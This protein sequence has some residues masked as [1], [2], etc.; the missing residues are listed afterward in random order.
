MSL[1]E[2]AVGK[3]LGDFKFDRDQFHEMNISY[4]KEKLGESS[5]SRY[6]SKDTQVRK[7]ISSLE[8]DNIVGLFLNSNGRSKYSNLVLP[9]S[10]FGIDLSQNFYGNFGEVSFLNQMAIVKGVKDFSNSLTG[11]SK[12]IILCGNTQNKNKFKEDSNQKSK[13]KIKKDGLVLINTDLIG[14]F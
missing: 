3:T 5:F 1:E 13:L 11:E 9:L 10:F 4:L 14:G 12:N 7:Y 2:I 8:E 6:G